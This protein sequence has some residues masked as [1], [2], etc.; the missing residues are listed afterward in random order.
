VPPADAPALR[1]ATEELLTDPTEAA[2]LGAAGQRWVG[3]YA[4]IAGYAR[5]L[6]ALAL[7]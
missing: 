6:A 7:A 3:D 4:D 5:D 1:Q 2:R